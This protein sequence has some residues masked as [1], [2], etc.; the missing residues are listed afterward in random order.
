MPENDPK[1]YLGSVIP[2]APS[3]KFPGEMGLLRTKYLLNLLG[4]PQEKIKVIHIAGTSGKG[5]TTF[6]ISN[7]LISSGFKVGL[8]LSPHLLDVKELFQINGKLITN[9]E[10]I[11]TLQ[12]LKPYIESMKDSSF[13][14]P[15]KFEVCIAFAYYIFMKKSVDYAV[16]ET[17]LGGLFDATNVVLNA[18][19]ISILTRIGLD[20]VKSLGSRLSDIAYQKA[21]IIQEGNQV[22]STNQYENVAK[23]IEDISLSRKAKI[24]IVKPSIN[25]SNIIL[26]KDYT[27]FNYRFENLSLDNIKL[28]LLGD[29]QAE[30][31]SLAL[32][33][34]YLLSL[35]DGFPINIDKVKSILSNVN[36]LGRFDIRS[37]DN[38]ELIIDGAHNPQK[39]ASFTRNLKMIFKNDSFDFLIA[40][41]YDKD[42]EKMLKSIIPIAKSITI[43]KIP[44]EKDQLKD[45]SVS[46]EEIRITLESNN[47]RNYKFIEDPKEALKYS[48]NKYR[49]LVITGSLYFV[50]DIYK[51]LDIH[52]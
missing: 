40:I 15:T 12:E 52:S 48:L 34:L 36:F 22:I 6:L 19:K 29:Y 30:N 27:E 31:C 17:G 20:H 1:N 42:F 47:F 14:L 4:N 2:I 3:G 28:K 7:L 23:V 10:Y 8:S 45:R 16:I 25:Y 21:M 5:S 33:A 50:S 41:K 11:Q 51:T 24:H 43:S 44:E 49:R 46:F 26:T 39:M 18:D 13:G 32:T 35:R 37:I 38:C 9:D